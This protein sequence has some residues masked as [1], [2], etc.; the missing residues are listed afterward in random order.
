MPTGSHVS[1]PRRILA[2]LLLAAALAPWLAFASKSN[3]AC[4]T[5]PI[6]LDRLNAVIA[7]ATPSTDGVAIPTALRPATS[8][9]V[10]TL[11]MVVEAFVA[12]GDTGEPLRVLSLYTDRYLG[13][14]YYRQGRVTENQYDVL[15]RPDPADA[16]ERTRL[17]TTSKVRPLPDGRV[18]G[19]VVVRYAVIP[20]PK[21]L[22]VTIAYADGAWRIDDILGELTFA[23]P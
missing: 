23:L 16:D 2:P 12:C 22:L 7:A 6:S 11:R 5:A 8:G 20:T 14:L 18:A 1:T 15:A 3:P 19:E 21:R 10:A 4:P 17:L 13:D 9:E